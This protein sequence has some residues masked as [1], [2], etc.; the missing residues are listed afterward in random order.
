MDMEATK[1]RQS[2]F[3]TPLNPFG[4]DS[5][6]EE[7]RDD[8]TILPKV[9]YH[10]H[11]KRNKDAVYWVKLSRAQDQGLQFSS[12]LHLQSNLSKRRSNTVRKTL[13]PTTRA[14]S[15]TEKQLA[16]GSAAAAVDL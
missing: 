3:F 5:D 4:G 1:G 7:P 15:H 14:E 10:S 6:E 2:V 9:H 16:I 8:Y 13:N 11:W 12:T